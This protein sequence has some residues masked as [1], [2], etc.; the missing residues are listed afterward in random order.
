MLLIDQTKLVTAIV[1]RREWLL[2]SGLEWHAWFNFSRSMCLYTRTK[3]ERCPT[4][5]TG[6]VQGSV[7]E[8]GGMLIVVMML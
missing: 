6:V 1:R 5:W 7:R 2:H 4:I 3:V 8:R